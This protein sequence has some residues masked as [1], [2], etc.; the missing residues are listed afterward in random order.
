MVESLQKALVA[1]AETAKEVERASGEL[2]QAKK[3]TLLMG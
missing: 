1:W 2:E 3:K